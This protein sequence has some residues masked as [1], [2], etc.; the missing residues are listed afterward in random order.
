MATKVKTRRQ[1]RVGSGVLESSLR[2]F[3]LVQRVEHDRRPATGVVVMPVSMMVATCAEHCP[4]LIPD[5][6]DSCQYLRAH[7]YV[8]GTNGRAWTM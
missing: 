3:E 1:L 7:I 8:P 4:G 2:W 5:E 6:P